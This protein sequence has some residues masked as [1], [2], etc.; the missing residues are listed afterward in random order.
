MDPYSLLQPPTGGLPPGTATTP[1]PLEVQSM[2]EYAKS[3]RDNQM[4]VRTYAAGISNMVNSLMGGLEQG[5]ADAMGRIPQAQAKQS[6]YKTNPPPG[7][8][9]PAQDDAPSAKSAPSGGAL[10][11]APTGG[12]D[13]VMD[14]M[15]AAT[16]KQE[17]GGNYR[18]EGPQTKYGKAIG[19]YQILE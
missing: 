10:N 11:F 14:R 4:P 12:S 19:K 9:P 8:L 17:S 15:A 13:D 6:L 2:Y 7:N 18:A 1:T 5:R 3:L 16:S